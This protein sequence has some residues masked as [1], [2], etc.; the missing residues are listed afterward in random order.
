MDV[1]ANPAPVDVSARVLDTPYGNAQWVPLPSFVD[2]FLPP[3]PP[4]VDLDKLIRKIKRVHAPSKQILTKNDHLW[5]YSQKRPLDFT[6]GDAYK[7]LYTCAERLARVA[8]KSAPRYKLIHNNENLWYLNERTLDS[9]PD[10]YVCRSSHDSDA[11]WESIAVSG[12]YAMRPENIWQAS[13]QR[14][15]RNFSDSEARRI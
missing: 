7:Y 4:L 5:G 14:T 15:S 1:N 10:A 2:V 3:M 12:A 9:L 6:R 11:T 13:R 8:V